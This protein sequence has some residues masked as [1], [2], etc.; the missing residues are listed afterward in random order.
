[1]RS[2]STSLPRTKIEYLLGGDKGKLHLCLVADKGERVDAQGF[3]E[4]HW[5]IADGKAGK[6]GN[7]LHKK[8][9]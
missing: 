8:S 3:V 4:G 1:M 5:H 6:L 7:D 9:Q 2:S